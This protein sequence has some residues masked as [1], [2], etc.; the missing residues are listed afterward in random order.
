MGSKSPG[1]HPRKEL[2]LILPEAPARLASRSK[3]S[4]VQT[5]ANLARHG[6]SEW[7]TLPI[8]GGELLVVMESPP[9]LTA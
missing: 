6:L 1:I 9:Q 8:R 4:D 7:E 3:L 5:D 2:I